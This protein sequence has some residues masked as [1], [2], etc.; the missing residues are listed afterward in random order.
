MRLNEQYIQLEMTEKAKGFIAKEA[1]DPVYGARPLKRFLQSKI[2]TLV[3]KEIIA[4]HVHPYDTIVVDIEDE[5]IKIN[6][7][8]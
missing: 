1:Y 4:G 2:E 7:R 5:Q 8:K 3:A 6:I